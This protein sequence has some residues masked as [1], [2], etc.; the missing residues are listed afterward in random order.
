[1]QFCFIWSG[2]DATIP[3]CDPVGARGGIGA[4][5]LFRRALSMPVGPA[6]SERRTSAFGLKKLGVSGPGVIEAVV[7]E[8]A[9]ERGG[10]KPSSG[11]FVA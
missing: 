5:D 10:G 9:G 4:E 6:P 11:L 1:M 7:V 3:C 2:V 8:L